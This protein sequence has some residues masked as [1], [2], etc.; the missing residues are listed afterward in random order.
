MTPDSPPLV[1]SQFMPLYNAE[2]TIDSCL[3]SCLGQTYK[4]LEIIV[5]I[6][7]GSS[8][9]PR[10]IVQGYGCSQVQHLSKTVVLQRKTA[11]IPGSRKEEYCSS[12]ME[13]GAHKSTICWRGCRDSAWSS[14]LLP[15]KIKKNALTTK[16]LEAR[17]MGG[18]PGGRRRPSPA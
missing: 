17:A 2:E 11:T 1:S 14:L 3:Q 5:D 15:F 6:D 8:N 7:D 4:N 18:A 13:V 16:R 10:A 12:S 9:N